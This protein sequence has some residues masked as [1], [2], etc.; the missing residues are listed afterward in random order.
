[1][2][3][4]KRHDIMR[5]VLATAAVLCAVYS[6]W[7][8]FVV[9]IVEAVPIALLMIL[10][11]VYAVVFG[12]FHRRYMKSIDRRGRE[13]EGENTEVKEAMVAA[14]AHEIKN[15]LNAIKGANRYLNVKYADNED[16]KE[17]TQIVIDEINRLEKHLNEF[18]SFSRGVK[19]RLKNEDIYS[20][21]TGV[22]MLV[23]HNFDEPITL[24]V[25]NGGIPPVYADSE[26]MKQ[27]LVNLFNNAKE[28]CEGLEKALIEVIISSDE[29]RVT[30]EIKDNLS[31]IHI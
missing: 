22:I 15:P 5:M 27:V 16:I 19:L 21:V 30:V 8:Y 18:M 29:S 6:L 1:M 9:G 2:F 13:P 3:F 4:E 31:L 25:K 17:F 23:K 11:V 12:F 28:A 10:V 20:L 24:T 14:V 26:Q 7:L